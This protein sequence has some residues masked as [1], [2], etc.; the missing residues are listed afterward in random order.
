MPTENYALYLLVAVGYIAS[1]G[2]AVF[3]AINGGATIGIGNT[4]VVLFGNT[5][6]LGA[7]ALISALGVGAVILNSDGLTSA[8][9]IAGALWLIYMG[10]KMILAKPSN[11]PTV[12]TVTRAKPGWDNKL[13]GF[14]EGFLLA[15]TNPKPIIFFVSIYPQFV[16]PNTSAIQQLTA[17]G[18]TFMCLSFVVLNGYSIFSKLTIGR[19]ANPRTARIINWIFGITFVALAFFLIR[20]IPVVDRIAGYTARP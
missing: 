1:P 18:V 16:A 14:C 11:P 8:I 7:L 15:I 6:G 3:F 20:Q 12:N 10:A 9:K 2:P 13:V 19:I 4:A 17:L 5:I